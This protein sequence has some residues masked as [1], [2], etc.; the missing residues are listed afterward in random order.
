MIKFLDLKGI[1]QQ[2]REGLRLAFDR[3]LD[4]GWYILGNEVNLFEQQF[5]EYCGTKHAIGVANGLDALIL[6]IRA[7]KELGVFKD[8]D[9][10]IVPANTYIASIL[11]ISANDLIPVLVEPDIDTYNIDPKLIE[12]K[13]TT[14][15]KA[16]LPVHLYGNLCDM[17]SINS[18]AEKYN[19]KVIEDCAQA[20]GATNDGK[21]AG[22]FGDAAGFSFYPGKNLGALGDAGAVTTNDTDLA[23]T[24]RALLNYGSEKKYHNQYKGI[25]SRLDEVQAALLGVKLHT[26][27][28]ET[29]IKREIAN[30]YLLEIKNPKI[31]LPKIATQ[32]QHVWH[33]FVVRTAN[34][35]KLQQYL[36]EKG[37]QTVI[38]YPIPPHKQQAYKDW[39]DLRYPISEEIHREVLSIPLNFILTSEEV[40]YIIKTLNDYGKD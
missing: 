33:L 26:L 17:K 27:N 3:V 35:E 18:I 36:T 29:R 25:N 8:N 6:I 32:E 11:A 4:S 31:K 2:Y 34:R 14:R 30:R 7:Y 39:N 10:I 20:H 21:A 9:E 28:D 5:A 38:H 12:A 24:I 15:T 16:I 37:I 40:S 1:N 22:N 19:L 13:I 23:V